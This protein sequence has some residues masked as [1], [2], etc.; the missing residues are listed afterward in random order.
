MRNSGQRVT[1]KRY[2]NCR[3]YDTARGAYVTADEAAGLADDQDVVVLDAKTGED[4]TAL[5]LT[6]HRFH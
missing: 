6:K 5:I 1:I 4:I 2:A 3:L